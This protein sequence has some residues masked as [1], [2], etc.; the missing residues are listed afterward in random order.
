MGAKFIEQVRRAGSP[1]KIPVRRR[2]SSGATDATLDAANDQETDIV[3]S[4]LQML[5]FFAPS[6]CAPPP[7][8]CTAEGLM[9]RFRHLALNS[10][11]Q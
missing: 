3:R 6:R 1:G 11:V 7:G 2:R 5:R 4:D 10:V 8:R 9:I